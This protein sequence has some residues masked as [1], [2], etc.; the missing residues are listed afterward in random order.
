MRGEN[1]IKGRRKERKGRGVGGFG[2]E[3][4]V[5]CYQLS[6]ITPEI[7]IRLILETQEMRCLE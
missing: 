5:C 1:K 7:G 2:G 4:R 3:E 6:K